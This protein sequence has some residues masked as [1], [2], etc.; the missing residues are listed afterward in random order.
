MA[1]CLPPPLPSTT[2]AKPRASVSLR[3]TR[4]DW[5]VIWR[6]R[7]DSA[8][9]CGPCLQRWALE[10][11]NQRSPVSGAIGRLASPPHL[12][13]TSG[14]LPPSCRFRLPAGFVC[15]VPPASF[16]A[17]R[18]SQLLRC[19]TVSRGAACPTVWHIPPSGHRIASRA[20]PYCAGKRLPPPP[21]PPLFAAVLTPTTCTGWGVV[22]RRYT[23][24]FF[25]A[26]PP[27]PPL[28]PAGFAFLSSFL[29][30]ILRSHRASRQRSVPSTRREAMMCASSG[31][32]LRP[33]KAGHAVR[34]LWSDK[35]RAPRRCASA[36]HRCQRG[37]WG[38]MRLRVCLGCQGVS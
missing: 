3:W 11:S 16:S 36:L 10:G 33:G 8:L 9:L 17:A 24:T 20:A 7:S 18:R 25:L 34:Q 14:R 13:A 1:G 27:P 2:S 38:C 22:V 28:L 12:R 21:L 31:S 4:P 29:G 19:S 15:C 30:G 23:R 37:D 6:D 5:S 35:G 26:L 32:D